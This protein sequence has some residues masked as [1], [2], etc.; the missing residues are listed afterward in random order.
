MSEM[1]RTTCV[2]FHS[3][4]LKQ[5]IQKEAPSWKL[6][7]GVSSHISCTKTLENP[8]GPQGDRLKR[9]LKPNT[10]EI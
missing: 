4:V 7:T 9:H 3:A 10:L 5:V 8:L 6:K 1:C 2:T